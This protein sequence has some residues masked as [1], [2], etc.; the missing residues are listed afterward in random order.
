MTCCTLDGT[1]THGGEITVTLEVGDTLNQRLLEIVAALEALATP[2]VT[3]DV[4]AD[5]VLD[6]FLT[7]YLAQCC[8]T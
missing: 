3:H 6:T 2:V 4:A 8:G 5:G 1:V 7:A